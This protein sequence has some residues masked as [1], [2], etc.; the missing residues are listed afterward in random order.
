MGRH[1]P[2][3]I[4]SV[5]LLSF[6]FAATASAQSAEEV[7]ARFDYEPTVLEVQRVVM[8]Y[9]GLD[10]DRIEGWYTRA[11][12]AAILPERV[13]YQSR[14]RDQDYS[15]IRTRDD[16]NPAN[17][18]VSLGFQET[19]DDR[20][21]KAMQ[22]DARVQWDFSEI[23]FNPDVLRAA[24]E[25][26]RMAKQRDDA[27]TTATKIYYERRRAQIDMVL[28]PPANTADR[29]RQELRIQ[30]LTANLDALTGGWFSGALRQVGKSP[31]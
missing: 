8:F 18:D 10:P 29:L 16:I 25:A 19:I 17:K 26:G 27:L 3:M 2:I 13:T 12:V 11:N 23:I 30:E 28:N 31:Y 14:Y 1:K 5:L 7:L 9:A 6:V 15:N 20:N 4:A 24:R 21:T 22:H